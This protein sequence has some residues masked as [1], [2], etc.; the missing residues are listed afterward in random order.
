MVLLNKIMLQRKI[1]NSF[2]FSSPV[3]NKTSDTE[4][5]EE[6]RGDQK[7]HRVGRDLN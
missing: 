5:R 6:G 2:K 7:L 1:G 4:S 3:M